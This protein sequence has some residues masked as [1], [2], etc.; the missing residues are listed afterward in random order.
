MNVFRSSM[1]RRAVVVLGLLYLVW[2]L[3]VFLPVAWMRRDSARD[4]FLYYTA[5]R[6]V[7]AHN[8]LYT[9]Q[10]DYGPDKTPFRYFYAPPFA[11][12]I[13]PF[14]R[15]PWLDFARV[16]TCFLLAAF[17]LYAASLCRL[18]SG[19]VTG[20]GCLAWGLAIGLLPGT[21]M[22]L[23]LGQADVLCW[24]LFG[25]ALAFGPMGFWLP[26]A[27]L[28]KP[29]AAWPLALSASREGWRVWLPASAVLAV[30]GTLT[31]AL[32]GSNSFLDWMREVPPVVG[33]G[34]FNRDNV[35]L[36]FAVLRLLRAVHWWHYAGGPL[37]FIPRLYLTC[38]AVSGP[39]L[40]VI[41]T[42]RLALR[43]R[44]ASLMAAAALFSPLCWTCYLAFLLVPAALWS[45]SQ[46]DCA[47][48]VGE[49]SG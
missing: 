18:A 40:A 33:Q 36:S 13:A 49:G 16:W 14:G 22:A 37:P 45:R 26:L 2:Q 6:N 15:L 29:Y 43:L 48:R 5:A 21:S 3:D 44:C 32:C 9:A 17:W 46:L 30:A 4:M 38:A 8:S 34:T 1:L 23:V 25:A 20:A 11:V 28:I 12:A 41:S 35:S 27:M 39:L 10:P 24:A 7:T 31:L 42:R 47:G 19:R